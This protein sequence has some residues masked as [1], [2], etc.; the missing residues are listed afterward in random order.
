MK[1]TLELQVFDGNKLL[2]RQSFDQSKI[3]IGRILSADFRIS[4]ARVSRI[5]ALLERLDDGTLR[6]TDLASSHGTTVNG[7]KII[8]RIIGPA[9]DVQIATLKLQLTYQMVAEEEPAPR[10]AQSSRGGRSAPSVQVH[11]GAAPAV[12]AQPGVRVGNDPTAIRS[13]KETMRSR[14]VMENMGAFQEELEVTVYWEE[15]VLNVDHCRDRQKT[16]RI[17]EAA[18]NDYIVASSV[19]PPSLDFIKVNGSSA[20]VQLHP[21]MKGSVRSQGKMQTL[22]QFMESGRSQ[23]MLGGQDIAKIRVGNVNFFLMFVGRPPAIPRD[24]LFDQGGLFWALQFGFLSIVALL[25]TF[26]SSFMAPIEG[27]VKEFPERFRKIIVQNYRRQAQPKPPKVKPVAGDKNQAG[28][29]GEMNNG[30]VGGGNEGEGAREEGE[31]GKRGAPDATQAEG[32]QQKVAETPNPTKDPLKSGPVPVPKVMGKAPGPVAKNVGPTKKPVKKPDTKPL[33][34]LTK[35]PKAPPS[36][37]KP[38][39]GGGGNTAE[40]PHQSIM[41]SLKNTGLGAK[42]GS[43]T[44]SGTNEFDTAMAGVGTTA[45]TGVGSGGSGLQGSGKGG[46]GTAVGVQG[47][48]SKGFGQ[49]AKGDG[50]GAIPGK[51]GIGIGTEATAIYVVGGLSRE[52]IE[53]VVNAHRSEVMFCYRNAL[54]RDPGIAGKITL[55]WQIVGGGSVAGLQ[56]AQNTSGSQ[57]LADCIRA[58]VGTWKFPSPP[59]GSTADVEWPWIFKPGGT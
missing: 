52:E 42:L 36:M 46:G 49:G 11:G 51:P 53:R 34:K 41:N 15:T 28:T 10:P 55:K 21:S 24:D 56:T 37:A 43:V 39:A 57:S 3:V 19:L 44:K 58:Q 9:D 1:Q 22:E 17:G 45:G 50:T 23:I 7:E 59:G 20:E 4:D 12:V 26:G 13:L 48:G 5:H 47:L 32:R 29:T 54:Q 18:G 40:T 6:L 38:R 25:I 14:G 16:I 27:Q 2:A 30:P 8:E 35:N 31:E 33:P